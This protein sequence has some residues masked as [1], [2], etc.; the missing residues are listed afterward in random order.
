[1]KKN[2]EMGE[3]MNGWSLGWFVSCLFTYELQENFSNVITFWFRDIDFLEFSEKLFT[4]RDECFHIQK[5]LTTFFL[6]DGTWRG[7]FQRLN[8]N[9]KK[10]NV[11]S[12]VWM[13][14]Q[15]WQLLWL[16]Y[17]NCSLE[18]SKIILF[19][20]DKFFYYILDRL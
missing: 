15:V 19:S 8:V 3:S 1:M 4:E 20:I 18:I 10:H 6:F 17:T 2:V 5:D 14:L 13:N 7:I 16:T 9:L 11:G 12:S